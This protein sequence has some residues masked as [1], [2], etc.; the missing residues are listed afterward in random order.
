MAFS[1][2]DRGR[3]RRPSAEDW[4]WSHEFMD[5]ILEFLLLV[6]DFVLVMLL[7]VLLMLFPREILTIFLMIAL[8]LFLEL[9]FHGMFLRG[10]AQILHFQTKFCILLTLMIS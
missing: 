6:H 3:S 1:D 8:V 5:I 9:I 7:L 2:E 4:G 10:G